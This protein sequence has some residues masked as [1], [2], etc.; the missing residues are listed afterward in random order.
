M[1]VSVTA[2]I[3][4]KNALRESLYE[5]LTITTEAKQAEVQRW[6]DTQRQDVV[7]LSQLPEIRRDT[8]TLLAQENDD[9]E[10]RRAYKFLSAYFADLTQ[11]K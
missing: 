11:T 6:F 5:K 7:L 10:A 4:A 3:L 2:F 9:S 1:S 8:A